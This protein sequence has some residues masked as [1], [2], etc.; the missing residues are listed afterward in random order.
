MPL[1][2]P[3]KMQI[4]IQRTPSTAYFTCICDDVR[5]TYSKVFARTH[6]HTYAVVAVAVATDLDA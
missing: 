1:L 3:S 2:V 4:F 6:T 5:M